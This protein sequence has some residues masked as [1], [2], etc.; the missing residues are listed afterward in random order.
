MQCIT[1]DMFIAPSGEVEI[2]NTGD[3]IRATEFQS[4]AISS[5]QTSINP[6]RIHST[7]M[8]V[9][10][11]CYERGIIG[12]I[13]VGYA[14]FID[15]I[16]EDQQLWAIDLKI[17]YTDT[18]AMSNILQYVTGGSFDSG[19]GLFK[20]P[21]YQVMPEMTS[22]FK[23]PKVRQPPNH[24][25]AVLS[26]RLFHTN[27]SLVHYSV[28]FQMCRAHH[29]GYDIREREG[30][31]FTLIDSYKRDLIGMGVVESDLVSALKTFH[32]NLSVVHQEISSANMPG[33]NNFNALIS[34][35]DKILD[36]L[37]VEEEPAKDGDTADNLES[38]DK[39]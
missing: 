2:K 27:L 9:G 39:Q 11:A 1:V 21:D 24:R 30:S 26:P 22:R 10:N 36:S 28:F 37:V 6:S 8:S 15:P 38:E 33:K 18:L 20:I 19:S 4:W 16:S 7:S 12:Y 29:I 3:Q 32:R 23:S 31:V 17:Q 14:T 25:F 13:S 35:V 34:E 5:P